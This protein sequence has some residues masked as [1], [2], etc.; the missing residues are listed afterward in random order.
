MGHFSKEY[1]TDNNLACI[2]VLPPFQRRG[3]G[4]LLIQLSY[5]L[6]RRESRTG[7]PEKPLSDLG[8]VSYRSYWWWILIRVLDESNIDRNISVVELSE[9]SG[10][11]CDDIISTFQAVQ[12][13]KYCK[14]N[15]DNMIRCS[16]S[17]VN[18]CKNLPMFKPPKIILNERNLRWNSESVY[19]PNLIKREPSISNSENA[20]SIDNGLIYEDSDSRSISTRDS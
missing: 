12:M 8:K 16:K 15:R 13:V 11:H 19:L 9:M 3:Y 5:A 14:L 10:I 17:I 1:G 18:C 6:S 7:T 20:D 4:K 2:M